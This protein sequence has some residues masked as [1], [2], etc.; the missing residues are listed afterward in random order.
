MKLKGFEAILATNSTVQSL[1]ILNN[2]YRSCTKIQR[3]NCAEEQDRL[4]DRAEDGDT[5]GYRPLGYVVP[6]CR[7]GLGEDPE[8]MNEV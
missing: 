4:Q 8:L 2:E 3:N 1:S 6:I 5:P 7:G